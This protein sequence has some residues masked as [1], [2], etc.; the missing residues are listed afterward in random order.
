MLSPLPRRFCLAAEPALTPAL[1]KIFLRSSLSWWELSDCTPPGI[2]KKDS[3]CV[4]DT[5]WYIKEEDDNEE[6]VIMKKMQ[7]DTYLLGGFSI[8][9]PARQA[10]PWYRP[11]PRSSQN[12]C[13]PRSPTCRNYS[14]TAVVCDTHILSMTM[15]MMKNHLAESTARHLMGCLWPLSTARQLN[16]PSSSPR[17]HNRTCHT[18]MHQVGA[19]EVKK[20]LTGHRA[21]KRG[22]PEAERGDGE[23]GDSTTCLVAAQPSHNLPAC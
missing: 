18:C 6:S 9:S 14:A 15:M 11:T 2:I 21:V 20:G 3:Y 17:L 1:W 5:L 4:I 23:A 16:S 13:S 22:G 7:M 12:L 19:G 10:P 8:F